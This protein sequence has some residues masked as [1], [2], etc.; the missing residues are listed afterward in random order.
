MEIVWSTRANYTFHA[1]RNYLIQFRSTEIAKRFVNEVLH[2]I[3]LIK[4]NPHLGK[5][6]RDFDC[7]KI[8]V[9]K[10]ISLYYIVK[11]DFIHLIEFYDNRQKPLKVLNY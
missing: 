8:L 3:N 5:F 10:N 9:S 7:N 1:T 4:A 11:Q 2:I 6:R